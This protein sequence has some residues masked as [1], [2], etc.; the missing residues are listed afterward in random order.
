LRLG[1][2][3]LPVQLGRRVAPALGGGER[4]M[5]VRFG[6]RSR[7]ALRRVRSARLVVEVRATDAHGRPARAT[8]TVRLTR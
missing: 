6:P 4:V 1:S 3:K 8:R 7:R 5:T 2:G